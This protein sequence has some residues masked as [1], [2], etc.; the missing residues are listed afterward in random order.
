MI[1]FAYPKFFLLLL[2]PVVVYFL[3]PAIKSYGQAL[4]VPFTGDI[5]KIKNATRGKALLT[6]SAKAVRW[7]KLLFLFLIWFFAVIAMAR[8][9]FVGEPL[10]V[11]HEGREIMLV[12]DISNS[13]KT[14][15]FRYQNNIL[16]RLTMVKKVVGDFV[17]ARTDDKIGLVLFATRAYLQVPL[18]YDRNSLKEVLYS[19]DAGMA[20]TSTS[21]GDAIGVALKNLAQSDTD[22]GD[23]V[24]ILLTDGEN[25]DGNISFP[26]AI[27]LAA[28][29]KVKIYTIG[30]GGEEESFLGGLFMVPVNGELDEKSLKELAEVTKGAYFRAKDSDSL[31]KIYAEINRLEAKEQQGRFVRETKDLFY[32]PALL[33]LL[34]FCGLF[35][36]MRRA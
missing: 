3:L 17:D 29:E 6:I 26:Q 5:I 35:L 11:K 2:L 13:M 36:F 14:R 1:E 10:R 24:I 19:M 31:F 33:S 34:L 8:P 7:L 12:V 21:I 22:N 30:V 23:K 9:Q 28:E 16:D 15:D 4:K 20:G 18:T 25:N 32:Y 27:K